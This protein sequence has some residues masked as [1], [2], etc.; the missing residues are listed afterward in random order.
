MRMRLRFLCS[1]RIEMTYES[2]KSTST[3]ETVDI[4]KLKLQFDKTMW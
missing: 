2:G 1:G 4:S 3:Q